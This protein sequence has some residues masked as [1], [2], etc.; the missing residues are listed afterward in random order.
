MKIKIGDVVKFKLKPSTNGLEGHE[1]SGIVKKKGD[2]F[3]NVNCNGYIILVK[4]SEIL[5]KIK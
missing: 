5:T 4:P 3:Y 2:I 1:D